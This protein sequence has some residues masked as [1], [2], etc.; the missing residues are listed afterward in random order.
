MSEE[1]A[2]PPPPEELPMEIH[3]RYY[4]GKRDDAKAQ[5]AGAGQL[6]V[7]P[8]KKLNWERCAVAE[9]PTPTACSLQASSRL[10]SLVMPIRQARCTPHHRAFHFTAAQSK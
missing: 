6:D 3:A 1:P 10:A 4:A 5:F 8:A 2:N 9:G 7:T